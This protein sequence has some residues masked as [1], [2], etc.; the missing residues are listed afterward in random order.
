MG[1]FFGRAPPAGENVLR[2]VGDD[3]VAA[4]LGAGAGV[5]GGDA[6]DAS[7]AAFGVG[8]SAW[9]RFESVAAGVGLDFGVVSAACESVGLGSA[10][11]SARSVESSVTIV[12]SRIPMVTSATGTACFLR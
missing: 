11:F 6:R 1:F 8:C 3:E 4:G 12:P 9:S 5:A 7:F 10:D 2:D